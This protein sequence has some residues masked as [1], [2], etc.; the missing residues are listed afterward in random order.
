M[1]STIKDVA[2]LANVSIS[3]VSRVINNDPRISQPTVR[4]V[5][6]AI[7]ACNYIPN[8]N[9]RSL[10]SSKSNT[11]G[12]VVSDISN[13]YFSAMAKYIEDYLESRG[14][15]LLLCCTDENT[16]REKSA[17]NR[18][19]SQQIDGLIINTCGKNDAELAKVSRR[20][21]VVLIDRNVSDASFVGDYV[22]DENHNAIRLMTENFLEN[23]HTRIGFIN[24]ELSVSTAKERYEAFVDTMKT[25]G[26]DVQNNYPYI[27]NNGFNL[28]SGYYG[29]ERLMNCSPPPTAIIST[30]TPILLGVL[31]YLKL[32]SYRIPEDISLLS[33]GNIEYGDLFYASIGFSSHN[34][35]SV[36][37]KAAEFVLS[38]IEHPEL[39]NR[40]CIFDPSLIS[41]NSVKA[42]NGNGR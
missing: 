13:F 22:A 41:R 31:R 36:G 24:G 4:N 23:G 33:Y 5:M 18:L 15:S 17:I 42:I 40:Q 16:T 2:A 3:T 35:H 37:K 14:Y 6:S 32:N 8:T 10:K 34:P 12:L 25:A 30:N 1:S 21:P 11:V 29:A 27:F 38:R 28:S 26:I 7:A 20:I 39:G 9:A 19:I